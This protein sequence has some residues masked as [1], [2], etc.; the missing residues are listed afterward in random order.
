MIVIVSYFYGAQSRF[1]KDDLSVIRAVK[2]A[3]NWLRD[4]K[5]TNVIIEI[6]NEHNVEENK[7]HPILF[8]GK[9][10]AESVKEFLK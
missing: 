8:D 5:F 1:L 10:I 7:L 3:S 6:A 2:T 4:E 9:G